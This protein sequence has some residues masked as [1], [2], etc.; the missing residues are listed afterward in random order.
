MRELASG[1]KI[2]IGTP[3]AS[4]P[5]ESHVPIWQSIRAPG[6]PGS[7]FTLGNAWQFFMGYRFAVFNYATQSLGGAV[8]VKRFDLTTP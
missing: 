7:A 8:T 3:E 1:S 6:S 4:G 2:S 5:V